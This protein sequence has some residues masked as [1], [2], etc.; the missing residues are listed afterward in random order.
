[1]IQHL[2]PAEVVT[3]VAE[4]ADWDAELFPEEEALVARAFAKRRREFTAGRTCARR[5][6]ARLGWPDFPVLSGSRRDPIW[7]VGVAGSITHCNGFCAAAVARK[8]ELI[9]IGI[10]AEPHVPLPPGVAEL[11]CTP[12]EKL[13]AAEMADDRWLTLFFSAK[14]AIYKAWFPLTRNHLDFQ[15]AEVMIDI[16]RS[17]FSANVKSRMSWQLGIWRIDGRFAIDETR[18][19]TAAVAQK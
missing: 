14:E 17:S 18:I 6:L 7:P 3:M 12:T 5:A 1:V 4:E 11:V 8:S 9:S 13:W 19:Y 10:D 16:S 15:D 2:L